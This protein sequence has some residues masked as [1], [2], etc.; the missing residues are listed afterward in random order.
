[1]TLTAPCYEGKDFIKMLDEK[2][3]EVLT[4]TG[5]TKKGDLIQTFVSPENT[6]T[7]MRIQAAGVMCMIASGENWQAE[8]PAIAGDKL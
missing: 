2:Y 4:A 3:H 8:K 1:M 6:F 7:I 5:L